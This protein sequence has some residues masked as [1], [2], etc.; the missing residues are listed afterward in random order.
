M[1]MNNEVAAKRSEKELAEDANKE[2]E[3]CELFSGIGMLTKPA[4]GVA[5]QTDTKTSEKGKAVA[6]EK[7]AVATEKKAVGSE[8]SVALQTLQPL[9][10]QSSVIQK[11][12]R[13]GTTEEQF[14]VLL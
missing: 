9:A 8:K 11:T 14:D 3:V 7:K 6:R 12:G 4:E 10:N 1:N 13:R 2:S 5:A